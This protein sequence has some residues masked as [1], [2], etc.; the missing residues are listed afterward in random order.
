MSDADQVT[1]QSSARRW[2]GLAV[3]GMGVAMVVIDI[4]IV[5]VSLPNV[6]ANLDLEIA[7]AEWV[8]TAYS[9]VFA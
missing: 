6:I 2:L 4:T 1:A 7:D 3:L 5:N 9:L 8:N